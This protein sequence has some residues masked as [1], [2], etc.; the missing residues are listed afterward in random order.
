M[1]RRI[2]PSLIVLSILLTAC[3]ARVPVA[4]STPTSVPTFAPP[5]VAAATLAAP[6]PLPTSTVPAPTETA[7]ATGTPVPASTPAAHADWLSYHDDLGGFTILYPPTWDHSDT[8]GYPAVFRTQVPP[9]TTLGEKAMWI[10]VIKG[11]AD[12][13]NPNAGGSVEMAPP[14]HVTAADGIPFIKESGADAG[15]GQRYATTSYSTLKGTICVTITFILH[16]S[17]PG[18]YSTPPPDYDPVAESQVFSEMLNT[19]KFDQ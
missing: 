5:T 2:R 10:N 16:S 14:E 1:F 11:V 15:A 18:M 13:T 17:N 3:Q 7:V 8:G 19:F 12:C 9:G 4:L 6:S